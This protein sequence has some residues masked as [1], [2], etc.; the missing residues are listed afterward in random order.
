[1]I[2]IKDRVY[3]A[4]RPADILLPPKGADMEKWSM[5]A[6]DQF[7]SEPEYWRSASAYIKEAPSTLHCI[8]PEAFLSSQTKPDIDNINGYMRGYLYNYLTTTPESMIYVVRRLRS[9]GV[10]RGII[11][12]IDLEEYDYNEGSSSLVRA[13]EKT[14]LERIPPR[15]AIRRDAPIELPHVMILIDDPDKTVINETQPE[16]SPVYDFDL[17]GDGGHLTGYRIS[18]CETERIRTAISELAARASASC[19]DAPVVFAVGDGNHSLASAKACWEYIKPR[20]SESEIM[21]HPASFALC[22]I[23]NLHDD[24]L[25]FEP[26]YRVVNVSDT[27]DI[28]SEFKAYAAKSDG[29]FGLQKI[30]YI[31]A[32]ET[33]TVTVPSPI[34]SLPVGTLHIF[35]DD[36]IKSHPDT[37]I[38]YIHGIDSVKK[39]ASKPGAVGFLFDGMKKDE[40]FSSVAKSGALPRKTFSMGEARDKRY[41]TEAR[42]IKTDA[43]LNI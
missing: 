22:E 26:I 3:S 35:L 23:V 12:M 9:G 10:R 39:L 40:L 33:G 14:V 17:Y 29:G 37:E 8:L 42:R 2:N 1:M 31:C 18:D 6:C 43:E 20:L 41:Y 25:V 30:E 5:I 16:F 32:S 19:G 34:H 11:G 7:T 15:V 27:A 28:I 24:S 4:F 13:T 38:D 36:Y 21:T